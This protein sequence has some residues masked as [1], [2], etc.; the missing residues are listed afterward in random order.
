LGLKTADKNS[1]PSG[2]DQKVRIFKYSGT[3]RMTQDFTQ[4]CFKINTKG[5]ATRAILW[6]RRVFEHDT[7]RDAALTFTAPCRKSQWASAPQTPLLHNLRGHCTLRTVT[8]TARAA[9]PG[10]C[11]QIKRSAHRCVSSQLELGRKLY[12]LQRTVRK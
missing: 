3:R 5:D 9:I 12:V 10:K 8:M 7:S 1:G 6:R 2:P 4:K 11:D